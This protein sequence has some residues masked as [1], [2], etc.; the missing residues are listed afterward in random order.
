[1]SRSR[2]G[3]IAAL[4]G[5]AL[6]LALF[7]SLLMRPRDPAALP[8]ALIGKPLASFALP[9]VDGRTKPVAVDGLALADLTQGRVTV[10]NVFASWCS[11]CRL[12]TQQLEALGRRSDIQLA[13]IAYKDEPKATTAFLAELGDPFA[14]IGLDRSG[15]TAIDWGVYGVPETFVIDGQ[16]RVIA[17][18]AGPLGDE[19]LAQTIEPAIRAGQAQPRPSSLKT[20]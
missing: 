7:G 6:L 10:V 5:L 20:P 9:P 19:T 17:R 13:G 15:R 1:M 16:G 11:E 8:S 2:K 12:E 4:I 18:F 3:A 14:R